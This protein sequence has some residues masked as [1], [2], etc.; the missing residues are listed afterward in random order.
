MCAAPPAVN[1]STDERDL[2]FVP[3]TPQLT[4]PVSLRD[5]SGCMVSV[6]RRYSSRHIFALYRKQ[7]PTADTAGKN[8]AM[9]RLIVYHRELKVAVEQ[10]QQRARERGREPCCAALIEQVGAQLQVLPQP[11][12]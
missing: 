8:D 7:E 9:A 10:A 12:V 6:A 2:F 1:V 11:G 4:F 3:L 5:P